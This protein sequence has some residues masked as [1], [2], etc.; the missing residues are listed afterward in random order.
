M[1]L[2]FNLFCREK[3]T[4]EVTNHNNIYI[5]LSKT[6]KYSY[7]GADKTVQEAISAMWKQYDNSLPLITR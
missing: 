5:A 1:N 3:M 4:I 2:L 6:D 7:Q